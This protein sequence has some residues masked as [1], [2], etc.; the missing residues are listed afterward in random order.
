MGHILNEYV[1]MNPNVYFFQT[2]LF[3][4]AAIKMKKGLEAENIQKG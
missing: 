4:L 1:L 2:Q 3:I